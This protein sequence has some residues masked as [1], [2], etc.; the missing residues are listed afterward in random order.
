MHSGNPMLESPMVESQSK[1]VDFEVRGMSCAACVLRV[2]RA[3]KNIPEVSDATV[4]LATERAWVQLQSSQNDVIA[5][6]QEAIEQAGYSV[7][8]ISADEP[9]DQSSF[10]TSA[11]FDPELGS[12][13]RDFW[14]SFV[15]ALP[16]FLISMLPMLW[17]PLMDQMMKLLSMQG[18]NWILWSFATVVQF[19]AGRRFYRNAYHSLKSWSPDMNVLVAMGTT[20]AYGVSTL[21]TFFP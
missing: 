17:N 14:I 6:V 12:L 1:T 7:S 18:W 4:N 2:E 9:P 21:I 15:F 5:K 16:V 3:I 19:W 10:G 8:R 11:E 13:Q 20:A